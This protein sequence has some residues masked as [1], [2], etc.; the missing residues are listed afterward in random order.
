MASPNGKQNCNVIFS[1]TQAQAIEDGV[2]IVV[3]YCGKEK[4]VFTRGLFYDGYEDVQRRKELVARGLEL[5]KAPDSEDSEYM[6]LRVI[7]K[8]KLWV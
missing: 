5:L 8:D 4:V 2:L 7:E 6:K 3:G 1:Y